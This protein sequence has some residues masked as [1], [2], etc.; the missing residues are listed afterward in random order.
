MNKALRI[1]GLSIAV[2]SLFFGLIPPVLY[3][4]LH[5]GVIALILFGGLL[6]VV[7]LLWE[8]PFLQRGRIHRTLHAASDRQRSLPKWW[9][10]LRMLLLFGLGVAFAA[11]CGLSVMMAK[12][13]WFTPPGEGNTVVVLG[14]QVVGER[15]SRMLQGRLNCALEYLNAH[16]QSEVVCSGGRSPGDPMSEAAVMQK[17]LIE[18]GIAANRIFA[19]EHSRNTEEN[20]FFSA[21]IIAE[22]RLPRSIAIAT[23]GFHQLRAGVYAEK[24]GLSPASLPAFSAW[25]LIPSYWVRECFALVKAVSLTSGI[26]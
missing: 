15:P 19:E 17:Y 6:A 8:F 26:Q 22:H 14:C 2:V 3:G 18:Q 21:R 13:A 24:A 9:R 16:P 23:D 20:L 10:I 25:G 11:G 4:I 5:T 1:G 7:I 12:A